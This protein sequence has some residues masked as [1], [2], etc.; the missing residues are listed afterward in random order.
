MEE[1]ALDRLRARA[2]VWQ[3]PAWSEGAPRHSPEVTRKAARLFPPL[4]AAAADAAARGNGRAVLALFGGS[5][6]GKSTAAALLGHWFRS[7]GV[8]CLVVSGDDYPRRIPAANDAER[9]RVF[10]GAGVKALLAAGAYSE[11][12]GAALRRL[13][14]ADRDADEAEAARLPW[15]RIYRAAGCRALESYLGEEPEQDYGELNALLDRFHA[16]AETLWLRRLG[17]GEEDLHYERADFPGPGLLLL[18]WTHAGSEHVRGADV[19]VF[20]RGSPKDTLAARVNRARDA[21]AASPFTAAVLAIEQAKL[22]ARAPFAAL[23]AERESAPGRAQ[24]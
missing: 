20:L 8:S 21:G 19:T 17:R 24:P 22:D 3:P 12:T 15:L 11:E 2:D 23:T 18:E 7:A 13:W 5:G 4:A 6:T 16:G 14:A 9:R 10:R 1:T